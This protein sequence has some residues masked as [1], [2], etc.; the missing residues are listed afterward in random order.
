MK[1]IAYFVFFIGALLAC[2]SAD[3][4]VQTERP[5]TTQTAP[6]LTDSIVPKYPGILDLVHVQ[7]PD[8]VNAKGV[9]DTACRVVNDEMILRFIANK[10][11][12]ARI[13]IND[14]LGVTQKMLLAG[15]VKPGMNEFAYSS[16]PLPYG[17]W[18]LYVTFDVFEDTV[19][20]VQ[21]NKIEE[22][23]TQSSD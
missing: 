6:V 22:Q 15:R 21:F 13:F 18:I 9:K 11:E 2:D 14:T 17:K 12:D 3:N 4:Q 16:E 20:V 5:K 7:F 8:L 23:G 10:R 1:T 19:Q